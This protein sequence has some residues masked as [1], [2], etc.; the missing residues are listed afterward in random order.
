MPAPAWPRA[1]GAC[2]VADDLVVL[3]IGLALAFAHLGKIPSLEE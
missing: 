2:Q 3:G 1:L